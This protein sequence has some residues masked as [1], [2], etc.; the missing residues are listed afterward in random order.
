MIIGNDNNNNED[1]TYNDEDIMMMLKCEES[2]LTDNIK[3]KTF[4]KDED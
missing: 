1:K 4:I 2:S 3:E